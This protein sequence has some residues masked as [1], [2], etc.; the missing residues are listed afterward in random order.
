MRALQDRC[1]CVELGMR[2]GVAWDEVGGSGLVGHC[3]GCVRLLSRCLAVGRGV[4][5]VL[6]IVDGVCRGVGVA[7]GEGCAGV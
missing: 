1:V 7:L 4:W 3:V 5:R 6:G 2:V